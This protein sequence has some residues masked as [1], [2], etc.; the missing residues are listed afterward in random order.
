MKQSRHLLSRRNFLKLG[1]GAL[2]GAAGLL[3]PLDSLA[4]TTAPTLKY[5]IAATDGW[6]SLPTT[7]VPASIYHP[8]RL[9]PAGQTTYIFGFRDVTSLTNSQILAQKNKAQHSAPIMVF[10]QEQSYTIKLSNLGLQLRPDLIDSHTVHWHGFRNAIPMF[11]GEPS[12][13]VAVPIGR[14]LTYFYRPHDPGTYMYHCHF[15]DTE[16]V[17]M[18]MTGVI[19]VRPAQNL[20]SG[21]IPAGKYAFNDGHLP[22][23]PRSTRYDREYVMFLSEV[24]SE[25][26]WDDA[27]IQLPEWSD[28]NPDFYLL[29]G[30]CYPDTIAP[31]TNPMVAGSLQY[32]PTSS[33][34]QANA[35]ERVLLRFAN[36]GFQEQTMVLGGMR[37]R[38]V[39]Q[40]AMQLR[41]R[42]GTDQSYLTNS[43]TLGPGESIDAI[44]TAPAVSTPTTY[45]LYNR[46]LSRA[47]NGGGAGYGGQM[48]EVRIVPAGLPAQLEPNT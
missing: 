26:H 22:S 40:D 34:V 42:D 37:M 28:Y 13:S 7:G 8:D 16:H 47:G 36:L 3:K 20:G 30:R 18:G 33:L 2:A 44:F 38:V 10:D 1:A 31:A 27:H 46:N 24:W 45:L 43:I 17:H 9:A 32:Q 29:N 5:H 39:G 14:S 35:G 4:Q 11:D 15:E 19:I 6:I 48:T 25:A 21:A 23:D 41:G 12:S